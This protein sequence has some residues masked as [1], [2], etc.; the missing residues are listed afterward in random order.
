MHLKYSFLFGTIIIIGLAGCATSRID[1]HLPAPRPLGSD[2][3]TFRPLP[4][5]EKKSEKS[6]PIEEPTGALRLRQALSLA[7]L[8]NPELASF[9]WEV[10]AQEAATLQAGLFPN[11]EAGATLED[12]GLR[13]SQTT[14][15]LGQLIELGG[16]RSKMVEVASLTRDL[17][18]WDY[19]AKRIDLFTQVSQAFID[20]LSAQQ[21]LALIEET[22]RLSKQV[23]GV[24]S[25]R[26]RAGKVS[27]IEETRANVALSAAQIEL[28][29]VQR[30][31][32]A[33]RKRLAAT[34][35]SIR[36]Q[37]ERVEGD[38][39]SV[40]PIPALE[41]LAQR[42]SQN[43]ELARWATEISQR[44]AVIAFEKSQAV[45]DLFIS[46]GVRRFTDTNDNAFVVGVTIPLPIFNRNQG[47]IMEAEHRLKR[48]AEERRAAEVRVTTALAEAYRDLSTSHAEV[49]SLEANVLPG[50]ESAFGAVNE[51]YRLGKFG[52][53]DVL[54]A[55]RTL[56]G[57][58]AQ[59]L[60]ALRGYH[61]AVAEVE[62]LIG[63]PLN[64]V[65]NIPEQNNRSDK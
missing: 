30:Q 28:D 12:I 54:D 20:V 64:A 33:T 9:S 37:F 10:R 26:V 31:L 60:S 49:R 48:A 22:V 29:R 58:R 43:P 1:S 46:G 5:P 24:V 36:P 19:E 8:H 59:Y 65:Q 18:G 40:S 11:P 15:Q 50:A 39:F 52:L 55:Q 38:L 17:A 4:E 6:L 44:Q 16:K 14:L 63:E 61:Q 51:G 53:L 32:G 62:R 3:S 7:L 41:N 21:N 42:L 23:A 56:F 47:R 2:L 13:Q 35:G 25:E 57:A 27:P 34:W 45:P